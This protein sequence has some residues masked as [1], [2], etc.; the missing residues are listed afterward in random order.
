VELAKATNMSGFSAILRMEFD[1][2]YAPGHVDPPYDCSK[3]T[4]SGQGNNT[5]YCLQSRFYSCAANIHCPLTGT[6]D[7]VQQAHFAAFL[8]CAENHGPHKHPGLSSYADAVPCAKQYGLNV[9]AILKCSTSSEPM[10]VIKDITRNTNAAKPAVSYFPDV[11][12]AGKQLKNPTAAN[13]IKAVCK[14][15]GGNKP[16]ACNAEFPK[17][18]DNMPVQKLW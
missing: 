2:T 3:Q 14:A 13:L 17:D 4:A 8:P 11:R 12:V 16:A 15:Y 5:K 7:P 9:P 10:Q 6:C 18:Q 1:N